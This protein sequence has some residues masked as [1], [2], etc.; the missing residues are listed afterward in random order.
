MASR[1]MKKM[2]N[3]ADIREVQIKATMIYHLTSVRVAIIKKSMNNK[4]WRRCGEKGTPFTVDGNVNWYNHY[5]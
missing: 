4:C 3:T 5:G 2:V 1:H